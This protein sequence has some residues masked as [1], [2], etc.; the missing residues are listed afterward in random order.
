M[1]II[2][3]HHPHR[4]ASANPT[5]HTST[6]RAFATPTI[7]TDGTIYVGSADHNVSGFTPAGQQVWRFTTGGIIDTAPALLASEPG[8]GA[9]MVIG[10]G[11]EKL[12][13]VRT[14]RSSP[15]VG[16][17]PE[18]TGHIVYVGSS[19]DQLY[20][21]NAAAGTRRWAYD[22]NAD[23]AQLANRTMLNSSPALGSEGVYIGSQDGVVWQRWWRWWRW[24]WQPRWSSC[25][26]GGQGSAASTTMVVLGFTNV[27]NLNSAGQVTVNSGPTCFLTG[28]VN[29]PPA[30]GPR[31]RSRDCTRLSDT[32]YTLPQ[33]R[34]L[35]FRSSSTT[36]WQVV[37]SVVSTIDR[38]TPPR[39][40][41]KLTTQPAA[42][43]CAWNSGS[44]LMTFS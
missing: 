24:S 34:P 9:S 41:P 22:S 32:P 2:A 6:N 39:A 36:I 3:P 4:P 25:R 42:A 30:K 31:R 38:L 37:M 11:D 10:S 26:R 23:E 40:S 12:Y 7:G 21:I 16:C 27:E 20:A 29:F 8:V 5:S 35:E 43:T 18:G 28:H 1:T 44:A 17:T 33:F 14:A 19:N 15:V 13:R